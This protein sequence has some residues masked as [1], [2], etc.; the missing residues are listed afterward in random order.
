VIGEEQ[1]RDRAGRYARHTRCDGCGLPIRG[2][3]LTDEAVCG[4]TDGPGFYLCWRVRCSR[5]RAQLGLAERGA[6][7]AEQRRKNTAEARR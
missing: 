5:R 3:Y 4:G 7:Y 6:F 2:Q 1:K